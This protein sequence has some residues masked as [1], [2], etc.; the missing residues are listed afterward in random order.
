[1]AEKQRLA[2]SKPRSITV[3]GMAL[4]LVVERKAVKN[5]NARL[6][7]ST[8]SVSAPLKMP[9]ATLDGIVIDLAQKLVRRVHAQ[10]VNQEED[11]LALARRGAAR[12]TPWVPQPL[13]VQAVRL[14]ASQQAC[15]G[16]YSLATRTIRLNAVLRRMPRWVMEAVVVHELAHIVHP[17]HS[18]AFWELARRVY[19]ETDRARAFLA[20]VAW[21]G[22]QFGELPPVERALLTNVT[23]FEDDG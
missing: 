9:Q 1:M 18:P 22:R 20:G 4:T 5:V 8:L 19:P 11:A 15:W 3:D 16:S 23:D 2:E 6:R 17:N 7:G 14:V 12:F 21:L 13:D 10:R